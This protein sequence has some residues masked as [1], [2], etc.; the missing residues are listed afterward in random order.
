MRHGH[1]WLCFGGMAECGTEVDVESLIAL[2]ADADA[3]ALTDPAMAILYPPGTSAEVP[4]AELERIAAAVHAAAQTESGTA[5]ARLLAALADGAAM[6]ALIGGSP[7][8]L[9]AAAAAAMAAPP[10]AL[11]RTAADAPARATGFSPL[12]S[13]A[14]PSPRCSASSWCG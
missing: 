9:A 8:L 7:T 4:A 1:T 13:P 14:P 6:C 11:P 12:P 2:A 3:A 10:A 5:A